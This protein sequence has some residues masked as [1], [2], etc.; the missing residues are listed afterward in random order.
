M[1]CVLCHTSDYRGGF[2]LQPVQDLDQGRQ[3]TMELE[4]LRLASLPTGKLSPS[5]AFTP[6]LDIPVDSYISGTLC[7]RSVSPIYPDSL[8]SESSHEEKA[9]ERGRSPNRNGHCKSLRD[10][11]V[12]YT[13]RS[14]HRR[15][16]TMITQVFGT[17]V[18]QELLGSEPSNGHGV[19]H[20]NGKDNPPKTEYELTTVYLS[21]S[22]QSL[23]KS[24]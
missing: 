6:L 11:S 24:S 15:S 13:V 8:L 17:G 2:H 21:K 20:E 3:L 1:V 5:R 7:Q 12:R 10:K 16:R 14:A 9:P 22:K 4:Q 18:Q 19:L 23:G